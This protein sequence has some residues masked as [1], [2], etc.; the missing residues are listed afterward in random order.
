[1]GASGT[2]L[3]LGMSTV[4]RGHPLFPLSNLKTKSLEP[5]GSTEAGL[6]TEAT[7]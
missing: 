1:M 7:V 5:V 4:A 6:G 2:G 3:A